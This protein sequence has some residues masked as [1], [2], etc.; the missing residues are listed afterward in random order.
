MISYVWYH[1]LNMMSYMISYDHI[2]YITCV[3]SCSTSGQHWSLSCLIKRGHCQ[4]TAVYSRQDSDLWYDTWEGDIIIIIDVI[5]Y[6]DVRKVLLW[7]HML[8]YI[9]L[10]CHV[11]YC[12]CC[13]CPLFAVVIDTLVQIVYNIWYNILSLTSCMIL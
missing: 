9:L 7:Y 4:L 8:S 3:L 12:I 11:W 5:S 1:I 10:Q 2:Y 13:I 6:H